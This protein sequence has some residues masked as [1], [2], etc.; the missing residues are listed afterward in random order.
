MS[1]KE[2]ILKQLE[3]NR[4]AYISGEE[5]AQRFQVTRSAVWKAIRSLEEEGYRIQGIRKKGYALSEDT[6]IL[7][8]ASIEN[9]LDEDPFFKIHVFKSIDSTNEAAKRE[10][11]NGAEEG[12]VWIA[13]EQT[14]GKG[15][16]GRSFYSPPK[17]G[18]YMSLLLRP[19]FPP[20]TA[21][22]LTSVAATAVAVSLENILGV[23]TGIKWVNDVFLDGKKISGT[24]T[25]SA[26]SVENNGLDYVIIGSGVNIEPPEEG[27]PSELK[28]IAG[29][30]LKTGE[31][32]GD[33][34]NRVAAEILKHLKE[35]YHHLESRSFLPEYRSRLFFLGEE[36]DV[37]FPGERKTATALDI[38]DDCHL[39][40]RFEDGTIRELDSGE[41]S[42]KIKE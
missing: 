13:E 30:V 19:S 35:Y 31:G 23:K 34:R 32:F 17:T 12:S 10:A 40:V 33:I 25:E 29:S 39:L 42:I 20:M 28:S 18:I 4:G 7:S 11:L 37:V 41:I 16:K 38:T 1:L 36:I 6:N 21:S 8:A 26:M 15:R 2:N 22:L 9:Y 24:L 3:E 27:F 5:L 14:A